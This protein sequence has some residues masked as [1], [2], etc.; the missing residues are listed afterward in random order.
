MPAHRGKQQQPELL[1]SQR[2]Y[3]S[4]QILSSM[5]HDLNQTLAAD[6]AAAWVVSVEQH[7]ACAQLSDQS[8]AGPA[9]TRHCKV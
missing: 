1:L 7:T 9:A 2:L 6:C 3:C 4:I 8:P 5:Q